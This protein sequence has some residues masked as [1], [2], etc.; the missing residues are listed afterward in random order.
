ME[1]AG[2]AGLAEANAAFFSEC[3]RIRS[4]KFD[5]HVYHASYGSLHEWAE[6]ENALVVVG[7]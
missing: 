7:A 2:D 1:A 5:D 4:E 6:P 3:D